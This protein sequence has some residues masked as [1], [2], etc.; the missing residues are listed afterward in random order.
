M[1]RG[2]AETYKAEIYI[3]GDYAQAAEA[4]REYCDTGFCVSLEKT[5]YI[6]KYGQEEGVKVV[7]LNYPRF[8]KE[9]SEIENIAT[10]ITLMLIARLHQGSAS[11]VMPE[12]TI[13]FTRRESDN[14]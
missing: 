1:E 9:P 10:E 4:L 6:Y 11:L 2:I 3:A 12:R 8:P 13:W 5:S 7:I 14:A